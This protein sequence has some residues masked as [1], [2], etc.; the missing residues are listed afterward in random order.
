MKHLHMLMAVLI[1]V[2]FVYQSYLVLSSNRQAPRA[3]KIA[4]HVIYALV[5]V[6]GAVMLMQLMSA[7]APVQWVFAKII[8]LVAAISSSIKAFNND[9][10]PTQRKTGILIAAVAYIGIVI[11]AFAKPANL[12]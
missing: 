12:F 3:V 1:I 9:A 11:L 2:L 4:T 7:N 10:T 8:L 5:I 6:S